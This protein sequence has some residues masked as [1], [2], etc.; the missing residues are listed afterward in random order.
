M[1]SPSLRPPN[2]IPARKGFLRWLAVLLTLFYGL[3]PVYWLTNNLAVLNS[4]RFAAGLNDLLIV[5]SGVAALTLL[6]G[7][8]AAVGVGQRWF[9]SQG[10][11]RYTVLTI[12]ALPPLALIAGLYLFFPSPCPVGGGRCGPLA[13]DNSM[14]PLLLAYLLTLPLTVWLL[15]AGF[16]NLPR[17]L[18]EAAAADGVSPL[19]TFYRLILPLVAPGLVTV[20]LIGFITGWNGFLWSVG[21]TSNDKYRT[22]PIAMSLFGSVGFSVVIAVAAALIISAP[23]VL[24]ALTFQPQRTADPTGVAVPADTYR[25]RRWLERY[26][27]AWLA[28]SNSARVLLV[29]LVLGAF[30]FVAEGWRV[31]NFPYALDYGEA[32]LLDQTQRLAHGQNIYHADLQV[33]PYTIAN[34]PPLYMLVQVPLTWLFGP[35]F[36]YGR[37]LSW[38]AMIGAALFVGLILRMLT[39]DR[40]AAL[41]G[42]LTL[43]ALPYT[44]YWAPLYRI[45]SLAL[46]LSLAALWVVVRYYPPAEDASRVDA[47][48]QGDRPVTRSG[49]REG[50]FSW[51]IVGVALLLVAAVY[52]RQSYGLAAPLAAFVWLWSNGRRQQALALAGLVAVLGLSL[53]VLL[54][55][56][57]GGGF[58]FNIVTANINEVKVALLQQYFGELLTFMLVPVLITVLFVLLVGIAKV[59][60]RGWRLLL[61][62]MVGAALSG[63]TIGKVGSNINYLLEF[64]V[65]MSFAVGSLLTWQRHLPPIR[66]LLM[67]GLALQLFLLLPGL[68]YQLFSQFRL[69][70]RADMAQIADL[71]RSTDGPLLA[72]EDLGQ[73]VLAGRPLL[74]QPFELT[75][76]ARAGKWDQTPLLTAIEHQEYALIL[77]FKFPG[78]SLDRDRWS[79]EMLTAIDKHYTAAEEIGYTVVYRP[80]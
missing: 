28:L 53:F 32:P 16:R 43:L 71:M 1:S 51:A 24:L 17:K 39:G 9:R 29:V 52:T 35:A 36:W 46:C 45:D 27:L 80:Q 2:T 22:A 26:Q 70:S 34:Y 3:F 49:N 48:L 59:R 19:S 25:W 23:L 57:T 75:Q 41:I 50:W 31:L 15:A 74:F 76:L 69:D 68:S 56:V 72:D 78:L 73:M 61:P 6:V 63:L 30:V 21:F 44:R 14:W 12:V 8:A 62:Y 5:S 42:G 40:L 13:P 20:G 60:P 77:I 37:L 7:A 54:N 18:T 47:A 11:L 55:L 79:E 65:A 58:Y 38:L 4:E 64:C 10:L 33:P 66:R 67:L